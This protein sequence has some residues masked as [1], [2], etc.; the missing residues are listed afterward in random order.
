M[1]LKSIAPKFQNKKRSVLFWSNNPFKEFYQTQQMIFHHQRIIFPHADLL[2]GASPDNIRIASRGEFCQSYPSHTI[3]FWFPIYITIFRV[4]CPY[5]SKSSGICAI[6]RAFET[7]IPDK[8]SG[9]FP[10]DEQYPVRSVGTLKIWLNLQKNICSHS[11]P[12][13]VFP[14]II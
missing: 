3:I 11:S 7:V 14:G 4:E 10:R 12:L 13:T 2:V 1:C 5:A 6:I 9:N 8:P